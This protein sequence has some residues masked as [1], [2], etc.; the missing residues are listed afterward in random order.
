MFGNVLIAQSVE[1]SKEGVVVTTVNG[2]VV[3]YP[4]PNAIA[5]LDYAQGNLAYLSDLDP[6]VDAP[7]KAMD[8]KNLRLN[9]AVPFIRDQTVSNEPL[10]LGA[11]VYSKGISIAPETRLTFNIGGDYREFKAMI[12]M[13]ETSP[14]A[15]LEAKVTIETD[16][17]RILFSE[18]LKRK[19][20]PKSIALDVKGVKQLRIIVE[21]NLP[22]NGNR[23]ILGEARVQK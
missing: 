18:V 23:V 3:K 7:E 20:K 13:Q 8:E 22:V 6:Q 21:A 15:G 14:D 4:N 2:V 12:G 9:V 5:K 17:G 11:D 10:K 16:E 1:I 19:D